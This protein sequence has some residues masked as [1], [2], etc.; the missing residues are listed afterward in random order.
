LVDQVDRGGL[1][2]ADHSLDLN[3]D[4]LRKLLRAEVRL[5]GLQDELLDL[6]LIASATAL[7]VMHPRPSPSSDRIENH[8]VRRT[9]TIHRA[10]EALARSRKI[11]KD[12]SETPH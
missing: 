2:P 9:L 7:D 11:E 10:R 12:K 1:E 5:L 4:I 8:G 6:G 3:T